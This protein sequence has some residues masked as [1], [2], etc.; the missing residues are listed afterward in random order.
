[1]PNAPPC[2][3]SF[4]CPTLPIEPVP[5]SHKFFH[6]HLLKLHP[7]AFTQ[8][9]PPIP[10]SQPASM[11]VTQRIG[12]L[13]SHLQSNHINSINIPKGFSVQNIQLYDR[14]T[15]PSEHIKLY[16]QRMMT[17]IIPRDMREPR[18]YKGFGSTLSGFALDWLTN[19]PNGSVT[20]FAELENMF[21]QQFVGCRKI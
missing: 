18:L 16:K 13:G 14:S 11:P 8:N 9:I 21:N 17:V 5:P 3:N 1:M 15:Y 6:L 10:L 4:S 19:L 12:A 20:W 2:P 7:V